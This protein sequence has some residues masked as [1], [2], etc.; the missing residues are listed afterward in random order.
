MVIVWQ[1]H[2]SL[3]TNIEK[4]SYYYNHYC[5]GYCYYVYVPTENVHIYAITNYKAITQNLNKINQN[6]LSPFFFPM[7]TG[8]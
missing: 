6:I 7:L 8:L 1:F 3:N 2:L 4:Y 5:Y